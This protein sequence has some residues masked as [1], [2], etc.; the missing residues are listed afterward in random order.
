[1]ANDQKGKRIGGVMRVNDG[2]RSLDQPK[3]P[4]ATLAPNAAQTQTK[5]TPSPTQ[6][7]K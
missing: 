5:P 7:K 6:K 4:T 2:T 3:R 1:M